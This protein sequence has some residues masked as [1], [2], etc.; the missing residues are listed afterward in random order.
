MKAMIKSLFS[1]FSKVTTRKL[2]KDVVLGHGVRVVSPVNLYG[3]SIG[4][5]SFVGPFV[6]IQRNTTVGARTRIQSHTFVCSHVSI[7]DDCFIGHGV[8]FVNDLMRGGPARGDS[9]KYRSTVI[10][11]NV[12]IGSNSTILPVTIGSNV[13]VGA[14]SVVTRDLDAPGTY[15]GNPARLLSCS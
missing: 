11:D 8:V 3:C 15:A 7:G 10:G 1:A 14:G 2:A 5:G 4:E 12:S 6:E 13:I 9:S